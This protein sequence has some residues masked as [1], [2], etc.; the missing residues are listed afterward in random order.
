MRV[1]KL[2]LHKYNITEPRKKKIEYKKINKCVCAF[3]YSL[4]LCV[5]WF[6][7]EFFKNIMLLLYTGVL[8]H[9]TTTTA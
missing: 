7:S 2:L 5:A 9:A 3:F 6:D 1:N 8:K 4:L